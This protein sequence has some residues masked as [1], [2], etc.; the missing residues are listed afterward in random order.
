MISYTFISRRSARAHDNVATSCD[1]LRRQTQRAS[2]CG[3]A[4][5]RKSKVKIKRPLRRQPI[6]IAARA[7]QVAVAIF[8]IGPGEAFFLR[9]PL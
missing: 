9:V 8:G 3:E 1:I 5:C 4:R 7:A 6:T 2:P